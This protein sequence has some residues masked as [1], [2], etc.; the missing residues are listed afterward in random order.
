MSI[1]QNMTARDAYTVRLGGKAHMPA[2]LY[3]GACTAAEASDRLFG[4]AYKGP[5]KPQ[6][7]DIERIYHDLVK[8]RGSA[9]GKAVLQRFGVAYLNDLFMGL[10]HD[11]Y[12]YCHAVL[13]Y[14]A[15]PREG[16]NLDSIPRKIRDRWLMW[17]PQTDVLVEVEGRINEDTWKDYKDVTGDQAFELRLRTTG[18]APLNPK[19]VKEEEL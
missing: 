6:R 9:Q 10:W 19:P 13:T 18:S 7:E 12:D 1:R 15:D 17:N 5:G 14:G 8:R 3:T 11:F 2:S 16:W 4:V